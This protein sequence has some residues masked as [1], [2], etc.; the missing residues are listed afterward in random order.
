MT[1]DPAHPYLDC[2]P[3]GILAGRP[4][5]RLEGFDRQLDCTRVSIHARRAFQGEPSRP[6]DLTYRRHCT[7]FDVAHLPGAVRAD[8]PDQLSVRVVPKGDGHYMGGVVLAQGGQGGQVPLRE[9][10]EV[11]SSEVSRGS[12]QGDGTS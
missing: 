6:V 2:H 1:E 8:D 5:S 7:R 11:V 9:E 4:V 12:H 3:M 10:T